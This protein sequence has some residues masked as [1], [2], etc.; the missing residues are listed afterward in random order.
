VERGR[1]LVGARD[2]AMGIID[3]GWVSVE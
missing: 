3:L 1:V 2:R